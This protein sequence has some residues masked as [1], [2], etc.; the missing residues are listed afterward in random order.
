MF[1]QAALL[2]RD[3][4]CSLLIGHGGS[5]CSARRSPGQ[6]L[7]PTELLAS[8]LAGFVMAETGVTSLPHERGR[9]NM[10]V[11]LSDAEATPVGVQARI[12]PRLPELVVGAKGSS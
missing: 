12:T 3:L 2:S 6:R 11:M 9:G 8:G 5:H 4:R 10:L 7:S 1:R